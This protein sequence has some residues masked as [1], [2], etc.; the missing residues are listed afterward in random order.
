MGEVPV[1]VAVLPIKL[2][3]FLKLCGA[4]RTGGEAK[5]AVQAGRVRVNGAV[6][7]RRGRK[8]YAGDRVELH[9]AGAWRVRG[10]SSRDDAA[11]RRTPEE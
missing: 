3:A 8:L 7:L 4:V 2:D 1:D 11:A 10:V 9:G 6:E 5:A